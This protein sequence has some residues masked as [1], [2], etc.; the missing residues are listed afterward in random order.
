MFPWKPNACTRPTFRGGQSTSRN[1]VWSTL[2]LV[3]VTEVGPCM[4]AHHV[5]VSTDLCLVIVTPCSHR[6]ARTVH[7]CYNTLP[8]CGVNVSVPILFCSGTIRTAVTQHLR[9]LWVV[10]WTI[11]FLEPS[12]PMQSCPLHPLTTHVP[13]F[14]ASSK[15]RWRWL[16][17]AGVGVTRENRTDWLNWLNANVDNECTGMFPLST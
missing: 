5:L 8:E 4:T 6:R 9:M 17:W 11:V 14:H 10:V 15:C 16:V 1:T 13:L 7:K 2:T 12:V 3:W